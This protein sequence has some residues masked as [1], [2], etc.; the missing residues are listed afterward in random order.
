MK[1]YNIL[2]ILLISSLHSNCQTIIKGT[3]I[4]IQNKIVL[5]EPINGFCNR[6]VAK[7]EWFIKPD[8]GGHFMRVL[9]IVNPVMI[10]IKV[11]NI[12]IWFVAEP[13]ETLD[14]EIDINKFTKT[15][16][17]GGIVIKGKNGKGNELF[18]YFNFQPGKKFGDFKN[19]LDSLKFKQTLSLNSIDYAVSKII[20]PFDSLYTNGI[21]DKGFYDVISGDTRGIL[22]AE[23]CKFELY[24]NNA[25]LKD[26]LDFLDLMYK[27]N[28]VLPEMMKLGL[29]ANG[30]AYFYYFFKARKYTSTNHL[31]DSVIVFNNDS[32]FINRD[33]I[34]WLYAPSWI[35]E[36][37]W[38]MDLITLKRLFSEIYGQSDI[39]S[40]L[41][42]YP[43]SPMKEFLKPPYFN[44]DIQKPSDIQNI[45]DII[46]L[47]NDSISDFEK[48]ISSKFHGKKVLIDF[49]ATWCTP[50]RLEFAF[51]AQVDSICN[52]YNIE[53]LYISFDK[54]VTADKVRPC[55][56]SY[57]LKGFHIIA[58]D[59]L[60]KDITKKFYEGQDVYSIPRYLLI[61]QKGEVVNADAPR[62]SSGNDLFTA[63]KSAFKIKN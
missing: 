20:S 2:I 50:C 45:S 6:I 52:K 1:L 12:P 51:N 49:W 33:L 5:Y 15:S 36:I 14:F 41:A 7:P 44:V 40:F 11:G 37:Y 4:G 54:K 53:H 63:M 3:I 56:Y 47:S 58:T 32:N 13:N 38:P 17:N 24:Q 46:F 8:S 35:Q 27:K 23:I 9:K 43:N 18:N 16:P 34:P 39:N 28:P 48:L 61:N 19:I 55:A 30:I 29:N 42:F 62:P 22:I 57:N 21:I 25:V 31:N 60:I 26:V 10:T 59:G